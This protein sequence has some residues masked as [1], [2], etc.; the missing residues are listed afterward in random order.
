M[1]ELERMVLYAS[2]ADLRRALELRGAKFTTFSR[3]VR[4]MLWFPIERE[5]KQPKRMPRRRNT[6]AGTVAGISLDDPRLD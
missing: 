4:C 2:D 5:P 6:Q 1:T 3:S